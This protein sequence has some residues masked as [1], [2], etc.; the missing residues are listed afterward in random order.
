MPV[1]AQGHFPAFLARLRLGPT[2][3]ARRP[4]L[5]RASRAPSTGRSLVP[6]RWK[7]LSET[8][9]NCEDRRGSRC[10][11]DGAC[12]VARLASSKAMEERGSVWSENRRYDGGRGSRCRPRSIVD[13]RRPPVLAPA[14]PLETNHEPDAAAAGEQTRQRVARCTADQPRMRGRIPSRIRR[15]R[16]RRRAS[17]R[18]W[19]GSCT[20]QGSLVRSVHPDSLDRLGA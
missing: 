6:S 16:S 10:L 20:W 15:R 2:R 9:L 14:E 12:R 19:N 13:G 18:E 11:A 3:H 7:P 1:R 4:F 8:W 17:D 5:A